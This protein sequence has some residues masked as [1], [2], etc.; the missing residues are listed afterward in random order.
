[1]RNRLKIALQNKKDLGHVSSL[2]LLADLKATNSLANWPFGQCDKILYIVKPASSKL[3]LVL[4][5]THDN[6]D[7]CSQTCVNLIIF[8][9]IKRSSRINE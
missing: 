1:L 7:L 4:T 9:S 8:N 3:I 5:S 6:H 2:C